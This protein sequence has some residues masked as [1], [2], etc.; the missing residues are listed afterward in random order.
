MRPDDLYPWVCCRR[1]DNCLL[2]LCESLRWRQTQHSGS[3]RRQFVHA[4]FLA[5]CVWKPAPTQH[6]FSTETT[7]CPR[8]AFF[9]VLILS[10][11]HSSILRCAD[12]EWQS[13][14]CVL[15]QLN[16]SNWQQNYIL[17][18]AEAYFKRQTV[19]IMGVASE[20]LRTDDKYINLSSVRMNAYTFRNNCHPSVHVVWGSY[21]TKLLYV[22]SAVMAPDADWPLIISQFFKSAFLPSVD[23]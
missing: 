2:R 20:K 7:W 14:S 8:T 10:G 11:F 5:V 9:R 18:H 13:K 23:Y 19:W 16:P 12:R 21:K 6:R 22:K 1:T 17:W 15:S 4:V 3:W